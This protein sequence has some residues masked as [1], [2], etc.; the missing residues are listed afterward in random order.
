MYQMKEQKM[1]LDYGIE[2][3]YK[4]LTNYLTLYFGISFESLDN[5][6]EYYEYKTSLIAFWQK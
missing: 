4:K 2:D 1:R 5:F 6:K 3:I